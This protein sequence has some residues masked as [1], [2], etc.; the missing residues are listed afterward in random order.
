MWGSA[1]P[2]A[3]DGPA[4]PPLSNP[5]DPFKQQLANL[6]FNVSGF[7]GI[8]GSRPIHPVQSADQLGTSAA[9]AGGVGR[10]RKFSNASVLQ[11]SGPVVHID[12]EDL[13]AG[14]AIPELMPASVERSLERSTDDVS[15]LA[16]LKSIEDLGNL[17]DRLERSIGSLNLSDTGSFN[18]RRPRDSSSSTQT[19]KPPRDER[20]EERKAS[21]GAASVG[22]FADLDVSNLFDLSSF[23]ESREGSRDGTSGERGERERSWLVPSSSSISGVPPRRVGV[24]LQMA[25]RDERA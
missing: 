18:S 14:G 15:A 1:P 4:D 3:P 2:K 20:L 7:E 24:E 5:G 8:G 22:S 13:P 9:A 11:R 23:D 19:V 17:D 12:S 25:R 10:P 6:G 16:I 21:G